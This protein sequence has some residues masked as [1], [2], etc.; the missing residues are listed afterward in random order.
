MLTP[1][2]FM[3]AGTR[4]IKRRSASQ[5][6]RI[7]GNTTFRRFKAHFGATPSICAEIWEMLNP[8]ELICPKARLE[9]LLWGLMLIKIYATEEVLAG[10][11]GVTEKTYRKW[12][13]T[14][15][16]NVAGLSHSLVRT[17]CCAL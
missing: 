3:T 10:I 13:W 1:E 6:W 5:G 14:F 15:I 4:L 11:A 17:R 16:E 12:A 7:D 8:N 2:E 9:H